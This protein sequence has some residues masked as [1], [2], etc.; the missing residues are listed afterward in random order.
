MLPEAPFLFSIAGL[1]VSLAGLA[2]LVAAL[3]RSWGA[4]NLDYFR[5]REIV[6]FSFANVILAI[7]VIP[8]IGFTGDVATVV[9][10]VGLVAIVYVLSAGAFLTRRQ[11]RAGLSFS[12]SNLAVVV[13]ANTAC[14]ATAVAAIFVASIS[15]LQMLLILLLARPMI[16]FLFVLA[17]FDDR[18]ESPP[19]R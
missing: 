3:R 17:A 5:L 10:G 15:T 2:G 8:L 9:R 1:S 13:T 14:L 6:E 18:D 16:A 4:Q 12:R 11:R 19:D 7:S